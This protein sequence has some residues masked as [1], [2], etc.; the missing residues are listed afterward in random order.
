MKWHFGHALH[1]WPRPAASHAYSSSYSCVTLMC[2]TGTHKSH[3]ARGTRKNI[4]SIHQLF[5]ARPVAATRLQLADHPAALWYCLHASQAPSIRMRQNKPGPHNVAL[6]HPAV[7][8]IIAA[9]H[10]KHHMHGRDRCPM[11][12]T[13]PRACQQPTTRKAAICMHAGLPYTL[14]R[15]NFLRWHHGFG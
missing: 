4:N 1:T 7:H 3:M 2:Y 9:N 14:Q 8:N 12:K 11:L 5:R 6:R 15:Y 10:H 13:G